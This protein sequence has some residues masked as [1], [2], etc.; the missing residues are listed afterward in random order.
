MR[1]DEYAVGRRSG[2][3]KRALI[4]PVPKTIDWV[5]TVDCGGAAAGEDGGDA[6]EESAEQLRRW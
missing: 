6:L 4:G 3:G 2:V 5:S 1:R